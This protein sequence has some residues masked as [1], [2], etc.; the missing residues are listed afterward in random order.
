[1][2]CRSFLLAAVVF[3]G[4]SQAVSRADDPRPADAEVGR[5]LLAEGDALADQGKTTEAVLKYKEAIEQLLPGMRRL[6]FKSVVKQDVTAKKDM[7]EYLRKQFEAETAPGEF[8]AGE[9]GM[10][11]LGFFP[12]A[13]DYKSTMVAVL[14]EEVAAF[15]DPKTKT[16]HLIQEGA[17]EDA[18]QADEP[19]KPRGDLLDRLRGKKGGFDKEEN[20]SVIAHELTHALADQHFDLDKSLNGIKGDDDRQLAMQALAEGEAMLT[21]LAAQGEDWDGS[22]TARLPSRQLEFVFNLMMPML[23]AASSKALRDAPPI[24]SESLLFPYIRGVVFCARQTNAGGWKAL[25]SVYREPPLSTEQVL[26]PEKYRERP[27][28]P[29]AIDLGSLPVDAR[30][31]ELT[32]NVV[33]EMQLAVLLKKFDGKRAAAG[34]DGD[35]FV[36]YEGPQEALGLVWFSTWD[37]EEDAAEFALNYAKFQTSKLEEGAEP[38]DGPIDDLRREA[39]GRTFLVQRRGMDVAVVEGFDDSQTNA[40]ATAAWKAVKTEKKVAVPSKEE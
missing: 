1:M 33:G 8:R 12:K 28:P 20:K 19:A 11:A 21:M 35:Q 18:A 17:V 32:R 34:W 31:K 40:L 38:P 14:T 30:W 25:D 5:Q 22:Q 9:L 27:D 4:F 23:P 37:T 7:P 2:S 36:V 13:F 15:Y 29:T 10:K 16:M 3:L 26:H 6:P 24:I 39:S